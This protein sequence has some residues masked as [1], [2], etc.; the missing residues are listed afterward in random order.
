ME[1]SLP[2]ERIR[3]KEPHTVAPKVFI[4][5]DPLITIV[6]IS[7]E[8]MDIQAVG[9]R[10]F[11]NPFEQNDL[12]SDILA[13]LHVQK[14]LKIQSPIT[15]HRI[16]GLDIS[17]SQ[18]YRVSGSS[19]LRPSPIAAARLVPRSCCQSNTHSCG[20]L[21]LIMAASWPPTWCHVGGGSHCRGGPSCSTVFKSK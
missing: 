10:S 15:S 4:M 21:R 11:T 13:F 18:L 9:T 5:T 8:R 12:S 17:H 6:L 1:Q 19:L 14:P 3:S 16:C 7:I 2:A 20:D